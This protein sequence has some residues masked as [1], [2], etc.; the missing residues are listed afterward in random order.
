MERLVQDLRFGLRGLARA[1]AFTLVAVITLALGIGATTAIF[2]LLDAIIL[3]PLPFAE[4]GELVD[5]D[6]SALTLPSAATEVSPMYPVRLSMANTPLRAAILGPTN[7]T[8]I[9]RPFPVGYPLHPAIHTR[10]PSITLFSRRRTRVLT[11]SSTRPGA[12]VKNSGS[13]ESPS[14]DRQAIPAVLL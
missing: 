13:R 12:A 5:I 3:S 8:N 10:S 14:P 11:P 2:T 9:F 6:R 7:T 1:P 4:S